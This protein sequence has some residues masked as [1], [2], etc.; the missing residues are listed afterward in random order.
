MH[1]QLHNS[2]A[3]IARSETGMA[4]GGRVTDKGGRGGT[5]KTFH[6]NNGTREKSKDEQTRGRFKATDFPE[7][8]PGRRVS[9]SMRGSTRKPG[10]SV[11][12]SY[13]IGG[14]FGLRQHFASR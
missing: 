14:E 13:S 12:T 8:G 9:T 1:R 3:T 4:T 10:N 6:L 5:R 2:R 7:D 11:T